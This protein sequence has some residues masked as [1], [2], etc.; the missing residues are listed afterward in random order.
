MDDAAKPSQIILFLIHH[1]VSSRAPHLRR[2]GFGEASLGEDHQI[3]L[4]DLH[5]VVPAQLAGEGHVQVQQLGQLAQREAAV[6]AAESV[7]VEQQEVAATR[8]E[9]PV[10]GA[11]LQEAQPPRQPQQTHGVPLREGPVDGQGEGDGGG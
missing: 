5:A 1:V 11:S 9:V 4:V 8:G 7:A 6:A 3:A 10:E 2:L